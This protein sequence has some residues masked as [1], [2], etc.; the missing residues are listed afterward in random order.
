MINEGHIEHLKKSLNNCLYWE[1]CK[2]VRG[3][4]NH[5]SWDLMLLTHD[6]GEQM[7]WDLDTMSGAALYRLDRIENPDSVDGE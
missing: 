7:D 5:G 4:I 6:D 1:N 3:S 2:V